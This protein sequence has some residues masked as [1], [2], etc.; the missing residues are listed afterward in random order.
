MGHGGEPIVIVLPDVKVSVIQALLEFLYTGSVNTRE[1]QFYSLM[2]LFY[3]LEI[4]ASIEAEKTNDQP[5]KFEITPLVN[6]VTEFE[7]PSCRP[8]K[9]ARIDTFDSTFNALL[10]ASS[11]VQAPAGKSLSSQE[12]LSLWSKSSG[13]LVVNSLTASGVEV[14]Q[15]PEEKPALPEERHFDHTDLRSVLSKGSF[16]L[17]S[18]VNTLST[19]SVNNNQLGNYV[20]VNPGYQVI[21]KKCQVR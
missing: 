4:N 3:D 7:C 17:T 19:N 20:S 18:N 9:R 14:K 13:G 21:I 2:K 15:E 10:E 6:P 12:S 5:T 16:S 11:N 1:G 8:R